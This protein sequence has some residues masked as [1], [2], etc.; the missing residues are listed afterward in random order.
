DVCLLCSRC[1]CTAVLNGCR[2]SAEWGRVSRNPYASSDLRRRDGD[3]YGFLY[4]ASSLR[5]GAVQGYPFW[6]HLRLVW[7]IRIARADRS[8]GS[9][10]GSHCSFRARL[11]RR[12][13][14][15]PADK[16]SII[17]LVRAVGDHCLH[18]CFSSAIFSHFGD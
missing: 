15:A 3:V 13:E 17:A 18:G 11:L 9:T 14:L 8:P 1:E 12:S 2:I 6:G 5:R 10:P 4:R 16:P 7:N